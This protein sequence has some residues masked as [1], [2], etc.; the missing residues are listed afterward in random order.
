MATPIWGQADATATWQ[1]TE[2]ENSSLIHLALTSSVATP[3]TMPTNQRHAEKKTSIVLDFPLLVYRI[4]RYDGKS[5]AGGEEGLV[6]P[7]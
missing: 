5:W 7:V 2:K 6:R 4:E 1:E 3:R